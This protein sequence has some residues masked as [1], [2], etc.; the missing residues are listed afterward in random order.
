MTAA[1]LDPDAA[2]EAAAVLLAPSKKMSSKNY[3]AIVVVDG[4]RKVLGL[5]TERDIMR[6]TVA[7]ERNPADTSVGEIMTKNPKFVVVDQLVGEVLRF[8]E[9]YRIDDLV[10]V[11]AE[12]SAVGMIDTQDL[13]R[14]QIV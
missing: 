1:G 3:G 9:E 13:T 12:G 5:V 4:D 6:R 10:V 2:F 8:L 14:L 11:D 7:E